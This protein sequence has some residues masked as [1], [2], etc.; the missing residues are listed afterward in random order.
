MDPNANLQEQERI[1][2][3]RAPGTRT[4]AGRLTE[5]RAA[6][7]AWLHGGGF[8]PDWTTAPRAAKHFRYI[9]ASLAARQKP[10][11]KAR[12]CTVDMDED[13]YIGNEDDGVY[14]A[15]AQGPDGWYTSSVVDCNTS[16]FTDALVTDDGPYATE[17][18]AKQAG[19]FGAKD[20]CITNS[21]NYEDN[22]A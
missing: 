21:V 12:I 6:L 5:L 20:W 15:V 22:E 3:A 10:A 1:L 9:R 17:A 4:D 2:I 7:F 18:E 16:S 8:Q 13:T 11:E 19:E 14:V